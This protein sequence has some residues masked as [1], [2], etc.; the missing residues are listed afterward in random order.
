MN[1]FRRGVLLARHAGRDF[2][3]CENQR[4]SAF[5]DGG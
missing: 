2:V 1:P 4:G 3:E 5:E